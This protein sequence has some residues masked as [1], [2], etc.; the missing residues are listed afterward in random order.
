MKPAMEKKH[1][2]IKLYAPRPTFSTDMTEAEREMMQQHIAY[3][4][5]LTIKRTAI[6]FGPVFDPGGNFGMGI[7]EVDDEA[8]AEHIM[9]N[10]P[11]ILANINFRYELFPMRIGLIRS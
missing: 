5:T 2:F 10:D 3:W 7:V 4:K 6:V 8:E 11:T 9:N 1:Y